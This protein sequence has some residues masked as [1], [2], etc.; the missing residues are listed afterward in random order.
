MP[1]GSIGLVTSPAYAHFDGRWSNLD[2]RE[3]RTARSATPAARTEQIRALYDLLQ[4]TMMR[5]WRHIEHL[6][7]ATL[8]PL[9]AT[10]ARR[11]SIDAARARRA[12]PTEIVSPIPPPSHRTTTPSSRS[13]PGTPSSRRWTRCRPSIAAC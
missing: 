11:I 1:L 3:D 2:G 5:A 13:S 4:E 10:V 7:L 8:R 12:R 6:D 9:A